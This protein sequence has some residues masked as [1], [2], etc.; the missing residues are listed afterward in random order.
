MCRIAAMPEPRDTLASPKV[1]Y[2]QYHKWLALS[3]IGPLKKNKGD[4][5]SDHCV[6]PTVFPKLLVR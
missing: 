3:Q 1:I 4:L 5:K 2:F 6:I